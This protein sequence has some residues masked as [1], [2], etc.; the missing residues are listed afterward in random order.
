M[1]NTNKKQLS[2]NEEV[3]KILIPE[4]YNEFLK[5]YKKRLNGE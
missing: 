2:F 1:P 5:H 4:E 3:L